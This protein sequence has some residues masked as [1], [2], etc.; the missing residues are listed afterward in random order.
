MTPIKPTH[1]LKKV[2]KT[3]A[4]GGGKLSVMNAL[5]SPIR[6]LFGSLKTVFIVQTIVTK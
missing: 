6:Q 2:F 3:E 1:T 5:T 4:G